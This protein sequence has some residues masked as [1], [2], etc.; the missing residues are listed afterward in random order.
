MTKQN[1]LQRGNPKA[2]FVLT[3]RDNQALIMRKNHPLYEPKK[4]DMF[5]GLDCVLAN[6]HRLEDISGDYG[7][8]SAEPV[9][10][11]HA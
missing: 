6:E 10:F 5:L 2:P 11:L 8:N 1:P 7:Y 9:Y 4:G 3:S